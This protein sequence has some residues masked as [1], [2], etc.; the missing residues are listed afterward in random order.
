MA[1]NLGDAVLR[2]IADIKSAQNGLEVVVKGLEKVRV[3]ADK[4]DKALNKTATALDKTEAKL[5]AAAAATRKLN[6]QLQNTGNSLV[7]IGRRALVAGA[8][9]AAMFAPVIIQG[10]K[11][12][13][14]M[15]AVLA[16]T[17]A[18]EEQFTALSDKARELGATTIFAATEVSEAMRFLAVAGLEAEEIINATGDTLNLAAAG[19]LS[20]AEAASIAANNMNVFQLGSQDLNRVV[21]VFTA[22]NANANTS[23]EELAEAMKFAAPIAAAMGQRIEDLSTVL[24]G[25]AN[26]GTKA[27]IAGTSINRMLA[28]IVQDADK[29]NAVL[30]A[31]GKSFEDVNPEIVSVVD[32]MRVF[33]EINLSAGDAADLF[34]QR[35]SRAVNAMKNVTETS[36]QEIRESIEN[37]FGEGLRQAEV[38]IDNFIGRVIELMSRAEAVFIGVFNSFKDGLSLFFDDLIKVADATRDWIEANQEITSALTGMVA[39]LAVLVT[40]LGITAIITGSLLRT[41]AAWNLAIAGSSLNITGVMASLIGLNA[42]LVGTGVVIKGVAISMRGLATAAAFATG[43]LT[44]IAGALTILLLE[45]N[46]TT[47]AVEG[48]FSAFSEGFAQGF[49]GGFTDLSSTLTDINSSIQTA[50]RLTGDWTGAGESLVSVFGQ[51]LNIMIAIPLQATSVIAML[52]ETFALEVASEKDALVFRLRTTQDLDERLAILKE[53]H[54]RKF[55][56]LKTEQESEDIARAIKAL[57]EGDVALADKL[58]DQSGEILF[59]NERIGRVQ[60]ATNAER[61]KAFKLA[62]DEL[63]AGGK[64][65]KQLQ[66]FNTLINQEKD[67]LPLQIKQL[68]EL[69]EALFGTDTPDQ[70]GLEKKVT[71]QIEAAKAARKAL[72]DVDDSSTGA[73]ARLS[74]LD[75]EIT[76]LEQILADTLAMGDAEKARLG[77]TISDREKALTKAAEDAKIRREAGAAEKAL[78]DAQKESAKILAKLQNAD[79]TGL[80]SK[81]QK[82][83]ELKEASEAALEAEEKGLEARINLNELILK[84]KT[85]ALNAL[86]NDAD[87]SAEAINSATK[88][89]QSVIDQLTQERSLLGDIQGRR[90]QLADLAAKEKKKIL[91]EVVKDAEEQAM[92]DQ[93]KKAEIEEDFRKIATLKRRQ[94]EKER[95]AEQKEF[96]ADLAKVNQQKA[97]DFEK[98]FEKDTKLQADALEKQILEKGN[99]ATATKKVQSI[100]EQAASSLAKQVTSVRQLVVLFGTLIKLRRT[101]AREAER[102]LGALSSAKNKVRKL[103]QKVDDNP[104]DQTAKDL[105]RAAKLKEFGA[106]VFAGSQVQAMGG[107]GIGVSGGG[108]NLGGS[109]G[110]GG[111]GGGIALAG[112]TQGL[113]QI[114]F[115]IETFQT[116][117][118]GMMGS[119]LSVLEAIF[120]KMGGAAN[121]LAGFNAGGMNLAAGA[122]APR[123]AALAGVGGA[124]GD[125]GSGASPASNRSVAIT[126]NNNVDLA[127]LTRTIFDAVGDGPD[128]SGV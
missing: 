75:A 8:A 98:Q 1:D 51:L 68:K 110:G 65:A 32:I 7:M 127:K 93:I 23:V 37:S 102:A 77:Q 78:Q 88:E 109:G 29:V 22:T 26:T 114:A 106:G 119:A 69:Q 83:Q 10:G 95:L 79:L 66:E 101:Q 116:L 25:L 21:D 123:P 44:L 73:K 105:L 62:E 103:Q 46:D 17:K 41:W 49:F 118:I 31:Y 24:G 85:E 54:S 15:D 64:V 45:A 82:L 50:T 67:L 100:E 104:Q 124:G 72:A 128:V 71:A 53:L 125:G 76:K 12:E 11:F 16:V 70:A 9:L 121:G 27:S 30:S 18:T 52:N 40:G 107:Q 111:G 43:G 63:K 34:G 13:R 3:S 115:N 33:R 47:S 92:A 14:I 84:Q 58:I 108:P 28:N 56:L 122:S 86:L 59:T 55:D 38:R 74:L 5:K 87:A 35:A 90:Q 81:L 117:Q 60:R 91:D 19:A 39:L 42:T 120:N 36:M 126:V 99:A 6:T 94:F 112:I 97:D 4:A 96:A 80:E 48:L 61:A 2:V 20:L 89:R 57:K 113:D